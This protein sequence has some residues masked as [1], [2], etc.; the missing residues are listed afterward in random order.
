MSSV[1][2]KYTIGQ[3]A[4]T[5]KEYE[6][7]C[8]VCN[9]L[10]EETLLKF[11]VSTA[12]RREDIVNVLWDNIVLD[13][14]NRKGSVKFSENKKGGIIRTIPIGANLTQLLLKY[15]KTCKPNQKKLFDFCSKT[16]YNKFQTLCDRAGIR[17]R[18]IHALRSTF[19]KRAQKSGWSPEAVCA[20]TGD[21]LRVIQEHYATPSDQEMTEVAQ[22]K[23]II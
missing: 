22:E 19:I 1:S 4:L 5:E 16:A 18:P 20:L 7:L 10:E 2:G 17:R 14:Q 6:K 13:E 9:S 23:E 3:D 21:T 12:L 15:R 8:N 11:A